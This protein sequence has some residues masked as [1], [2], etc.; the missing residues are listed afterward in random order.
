MFCG[1]PEQILH[2][3]LARK[4]I[5]SDGKQSVVVICSVSLWVQSIAKF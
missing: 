2:F 4:E 3:M 5:L 1:V